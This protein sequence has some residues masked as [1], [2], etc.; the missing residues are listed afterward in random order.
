MGR[1]ATGVGTLIGVRVHPPV[2]DWVDAERSKL[3]P[4][5]TRPEFIRQ[6][7]E[8]RMSIV[9]E[10]PPPAATATQP[11][12]PTGTAD[13]D[14]LPPTWIREAAARFLFL[15]ARL[16]RN[17]PGSNAIRLAQADFYE[18]LAEIA[19]EG[20]LPHKPLPKCD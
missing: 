5:P 19:L 9:V 2:L 11:D 12:A 3:E 16:I 14:P 1:P 13:A 4:A 20:R 10:D 15:G 7:I 18:R 8:E 6:I 17:R